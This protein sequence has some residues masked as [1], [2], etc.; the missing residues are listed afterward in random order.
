MA[1]SDEIKKLLEGAIGDWFQDNIVKDILIGRDFLDPNVIRYPKWVAQQEDDLWE[2]KP[3]LEIGRFVSPENLVYDNIQVESITS[4]LSFNLYEW[5]MHFIEN[6]IDHLKFETRPI[7][8]RDNAIEVLFEK[9][10]LTEIPDY[11]QD[12]SSNFKIK[13]LTLDELSKLI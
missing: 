3:R 5:K 4:N 2:W 13:S 11:Y 7:H 1:K 12:R 9:K 8:R 6:L 10:Y